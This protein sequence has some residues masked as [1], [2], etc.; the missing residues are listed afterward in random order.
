MDP[1]ILK[2]NS[3]HLECMNPILDEYN[4]EYANF[5]FIDDLNINVNESSLIK[6]V[7]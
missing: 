3:H 6:R 5:V 2:S 4:S 1:A 7:L